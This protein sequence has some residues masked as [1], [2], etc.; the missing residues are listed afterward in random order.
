MSKRILHTKEA[1]LTNLTIL[2]FFTYSR[3]ALFKQIIISVSFISPDLKKRFGFISLH[4][5]KDRNEESRETGSGHVI[6]WAEHGSYGG[7]GR[8]DGERH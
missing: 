5:K 4:K 1:R 7:R 3:N 6:M 2:A 8:G